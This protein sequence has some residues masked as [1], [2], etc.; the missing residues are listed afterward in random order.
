MGYLNKV[1][2][3]GNLGV[4]PEI[5]TS[6]SGTP[7]CRLRLATSEKVD[8]G[9]GEKEARTEWH[10]VIAFGRL[11][12]ISRDYLR[13]GR[14]IYV[15]GKLHTRSFQKED[16]SPQKYTEIWAR[17]IQFMSSSDGK[18]VGKHQEKEGVNEGPDAGDYPCLPARAE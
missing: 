17:E 13:K 11:A 12:E 4:D 15:E 3:I 2:L 8:H 9:D 1:L 5:K 7:V 6:A 14:S 16:G 10:T 18:G